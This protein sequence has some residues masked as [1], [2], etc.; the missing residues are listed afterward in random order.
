MIP[1]EILGKKLIYEG[2]Y[3]NSG[4][5][6]GVGLDIDWEE[7]ISGVTEMFEIFLEVPVMSA[8]TFVKIHR[9]KHLKVYTFHYMQ[10]LP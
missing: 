9:I 4:F 1:C 7:A 8:Y 10:I 3:Q 2:K 5:I 6:W